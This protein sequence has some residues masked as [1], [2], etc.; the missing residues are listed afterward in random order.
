MRGIA[1]AG[2]LGL[3]LLTPTHA[4][5]QT[6][7]G[8]P[9][10]QSPSVTAT[11][12]ADTIAIG[13]AFDLQI[14]VLLPSGQTLFLPDSLDSTDALAPAGRVVWAE[15]V[16]DGVRSLEVTYPLIALDVGVV[17]VPR[18]EILVGSGGPLDAPAVIPVYAVG[19]ADATTGGLLRVAVPEQRLFVASV[20]LMEDITQG[21]V[22]RPAADVW[23]GDWHGPSIFWIVA[24]TLLLG[25]VLTVSARDLLAYQGRTRS[26]ARAPVPPRE[27]ALDLFDRLL[28][29]GLHSDG[30]V[31]EFYHETSDILRRYVESLDEAWGSA[32]TST[33]LMRALSAHRDKQSEALLEAEMGAAEAV[34]FG[35]RRPPSEVAESHWRVLR[36]WV[37]GAEGPG[38]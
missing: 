28:A 29:R 14:T 9:A 33:E 30:R 7:G 26:E 31:D 21:I 38:S 20:L 6:A 35:R 3:A 25:G 36:D 37:A 2:L 17:T 23:G 19:E 4:A 1:E 34:K 15:R 27:Q 10:A 5:A 12:S 8:S 13:D 32:L 11:L 24:S 16:S 22:P 18:F